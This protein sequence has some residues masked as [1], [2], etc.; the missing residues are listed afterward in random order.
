[1][2]KKALLF[3]SIFTVG[4]LHAQVEMQHAIL[5]IQQFKR[6]YIEI[7]GGTIKNS[8]LDGANG[9]KE[10]LHQHTYTWSVEFGFPKKDFVLGP[11]F[12]YKYD[13]DPLSLGTGLI[14]YTNFSKADALF[15]R[16]EIG[17]SIPFFELSYGYNIPLTGNSIKELTNTH[18]IIFRFYVPVGIKF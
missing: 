1:M 8:I 10:I 7:G 13:I 15:I 17:I 12:T 16:P 18:N 6:T 5:G 2:W 3:V 14:Y 11:K 4:Q 9:A